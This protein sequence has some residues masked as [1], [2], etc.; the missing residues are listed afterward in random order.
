MRRYQYTTD[1][2]VVRTVGEEMARVPRGN[3]NFGAPDEG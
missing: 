1:L 3:L 2:Q